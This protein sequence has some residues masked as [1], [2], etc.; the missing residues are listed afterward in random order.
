MDE[1]A[2]VRANKQMIKEDGRI[3]SEDK[4]C[5]DCYRRNH[6]GTPWEELIVPW[7]LRN[8]PV[9][10]AQRDLRARRQAAARAAPARKMFIV[11]L[12]K[13][14]LAWNLDFG[15][16][17]KDVANLA[18]ILLR[19]KRSTPAAAG[20]SSGSEDDE[21]ASADEQAVESGD[22]MTSDDDDD[23]DEQAQSDQDASESND[24]MQ[25]SQKQKRSKG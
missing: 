11:R 18:I 9:Y 4:I 6:R 3:V 8:D 19:M 23:D 22:D 17:P 24:S 25:H 15:T 13:L 14:E 10:K 20:D 5:A 12:T 7:D 16:H 1:K 21:E 2:Q